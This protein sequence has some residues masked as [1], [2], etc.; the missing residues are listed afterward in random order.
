VT[1]PDRTFAFDDQL[2]RVPL[3]TLETSGARFLQWCAPLL[4]DEQYAETERAVEDLLRPDGPVAG[5][6][7]SGRRGIWAGATGS[8]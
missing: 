1:D 6:T 5:S 8:R 7:S 4:T 2:P 3:P